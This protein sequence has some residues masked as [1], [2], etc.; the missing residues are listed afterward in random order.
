MSGPAGSCHCGA[1]R[2]TLPHAPAEVTRCNCTL[3]TKLGTR[4]AYFS[5]GSVTF[6]GGPLDGYVRGDAKKPSLTT[7]RCAHCGSVTHWTA[8]GEYDRIG[9]NLNLFDPDLVDALPVKACDGRSWPV[10]AP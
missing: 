9:I 7:H 2:L 3:C 10:D 8:I 6:A 1:V 4:W 5:P